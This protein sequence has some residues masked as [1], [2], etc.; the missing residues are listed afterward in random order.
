MIHLHLPMYAYYF[1]IMESKKNTN[2]D[3]HWGSGMSQI[4]NKKD[5]TVNVGVELVPV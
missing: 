4:A 1:V 2:H 5:S 3:P